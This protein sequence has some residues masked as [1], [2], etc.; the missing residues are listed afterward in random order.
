[1][2]TSCRSTAEAITS[3]TT[4]SQMA[5]SPTGLTRDIVSS[6][7]L[8]KRLSSIEVLQQ[9]NHSRALAE[10]FKPRE[11]IVIQLPQ[12]ARNNTPIT[13]CDTPCPDDIKIKGPERRPTPRS[14]SHNDGPT[15]MTAEHPEQPREV[16]ASNSPRP[17]PGYASRIPIRARSTPSRG[18]GVW[19]AP[20]RSVRTMAHTHIHT[21]SQAGQTVKPRQ[22]LVAGVVVLRGR[23]KKKR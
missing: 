17:C 12:L 19:T 22:I 16:R 14:H 3:L 15:E 18:C 13:S 20:S 4:F 2:P 5:T 9:A 21:C 10:V 23:E 11:P 1:M 7:R 8:L 6:T